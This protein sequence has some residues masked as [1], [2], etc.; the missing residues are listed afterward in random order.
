MDLPNRKPIRLQDYDYSQ[1]G[2][3]FVTICT[4]GRKMLFGDVG[5]DSIS[6]RTVKRTFLETLA[7]YPNVDSPIFVVMP[8]HFHAILTIERADIESAPTVS[9]VIQSFKRYSTLEYIKLVKSGM[10]PSFDGQIWQRSFHDHVIRGD[11]DYREIW[12]YIDQNPAKWA[13]DRYYEK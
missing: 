1:P 9:Q 3:Y 6:A 10:V 5:A 13:E 4:K 11:A 2:A 7:Q 8:N 12:E